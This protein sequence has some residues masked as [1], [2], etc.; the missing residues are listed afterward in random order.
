M[1]KI[2]LGAE[3]GSQ[4]PIFIS[5]QLTTQEKEQLVASLKK[6]VDVFIWTYDEMLDLD[7]GL[8]VHSLN[9]DPG[10]KSVIQPAGVFHT[11]VEAQIT[12]E[13]KNLL[14][15]GFIKPI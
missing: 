4:K 2:Y 8:V 15:A 13:V 14:V 12:Q 5:N 1:G 9:V 3:L 10:V 11:D 6:Y 7:P